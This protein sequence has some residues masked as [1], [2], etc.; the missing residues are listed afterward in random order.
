MIQILVL[1]SFLIG[2][3][4]WIFYGLA[5]SKT[6]EPKTDEARYRELLLTS[7][8]ISLAFSAE[9]GRLGIAV[10][11]FHRLLQIPDRYFKQFDAQSER[12]LASGYLTNISITVSTARSHRGKV[13]R[14]LACVPEA[15]DIV[16]WQISWR[17]NAVAVMCRPQDEF[18]LRHALGQ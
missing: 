13:T 16:R 5:P 18:R 14:Q 4:L 3:V 15:W 7:R 2:M 1:V 9:S 11:L 12:L 8:S 17:S 6:D 10:R